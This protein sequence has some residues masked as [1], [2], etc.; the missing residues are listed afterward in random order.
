MTSTR[1]SSK[2]GL[3]LIELIIAIVFFAL[4]SASCIQLFVKA[5]TLS[6]KSS[7]LNTAVIQAQNAAELFKAS[8]GDAERLSQLLD[9]RY[10]AADGEDN[11]HA[12]NYVL[13]FDADWK[14]VEDGSDVYS[15]VLNMS[16]G[17][18][19]VTAYITVNKTVTGEDIYNLSAKSYVGQ[20]DEA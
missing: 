5:H 2:S 7:D 1:S 15:V 16:C 17:Q 10:A 14:R 9:C 19:I 20:G 12:A 8:G 18:E 6:A 13:N 4:S 3:F 11:Y